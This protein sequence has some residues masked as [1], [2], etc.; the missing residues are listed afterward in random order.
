MNNNTK[1][2]DLTVKQFLRMLQKSDLTVGQFLR[3]FQE[4]VTVED[5]T[6]ISQSDS[7][8]DSNS[9][10]VSS[11]LV[12]E[13]LIREQITSLIHEIGIPAHIKGYNYIRESL[14]LLFKD[15]EAID[16]ITK[17]LYPTIAKKFNT[18]P[19][20]VERAIRHA[21]EVAWSRGNTD[22]LEELFGYTINSD[23]GKPT[24][25]EFLA[26]I[27]DGLRLEFKKQ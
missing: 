5:A 3:M 6:L 27:A 13:N 11:N 8:S 20:R 24:N 22:I 7:D 15:L 2:L 25:S 17:Y 16:D 23:R 19:S 4:K 12:D 9:E 1:I 10:D 14:L 18:T 26:I 21:I